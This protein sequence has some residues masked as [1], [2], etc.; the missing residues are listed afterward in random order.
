[1]WERAGARLWL[2][3]SVATLFLL[4]VL[5]QPVLA[6]ICLSGEWYAMA[7]QVQR[8]IVIMLALVAVAV[9]LLYVS[10]PSSMTANR[11][12]A[13]RACDVAE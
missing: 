2:L 4:A 5:A 11:R 8:G 13:A 10:S 6:G 3:R 7:A 12:V 9:A 1:M